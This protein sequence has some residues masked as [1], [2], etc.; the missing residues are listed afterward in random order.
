MAVRQVLS[1]GE[2]GVCLRLVSTGPRVFI[3]GAFRSAIRPSVGPGS[4]AGRESI[5]TCP[6]RVW[7]DFSTFTSPVDG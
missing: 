7:K 3:Q 2:L 6:G 1:E 5:Q 4:S